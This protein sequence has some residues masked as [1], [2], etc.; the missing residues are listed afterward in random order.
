MHAIQ[1]NSKIKTFESKTQKAIRKHQK[2]SLLDLISSKERPFSGLKRAR[3]N[4][5]FSSVNYNIIALLTTL[6]CSKT[7]ISHDK[8]QPFGFVTWKI[9]WYISNHVLNVNIDTIFLICMTLP[10]KQ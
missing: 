7:N 2:G 5:V 3:K 10:Q 4:H 1:Y 6:F 9:S 8:K